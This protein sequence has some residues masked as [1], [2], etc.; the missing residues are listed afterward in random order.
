MAYKGTNQMSDLTFTLTVANTKNNDM[1]A[2]IHKII[3]EA[4]EAYNAPLRQ[5]NRLQIVLTEDTKAQVNAEL[6][7]ALKVAADAL[8][9]TIT[10]GPAYI[11]LDKSGVNTAFNQAT[12]AIT[13]AEANEQV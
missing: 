3:T 12:S 9:Y 7:A 13:K 6:L 5:Q 4:I 8:R 2:T 10:F 1:A 11:L